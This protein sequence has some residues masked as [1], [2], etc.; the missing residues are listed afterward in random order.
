MALADSHDEV[1]ASATARSYHRRQFLAT[2]A[3]LVAVGTGCSAPSRQRPAGGV[4]KPKVVRRPLPTVESGTFYSKARHRTVGWTISYPPNLRSHVG[5]PLIFALHPYTGNHSFPMGG[6]PPA[7]LLT[8]RPGRAVIP[9]VAVAA[10]D[11]GNGYWHRHPGDDPMMMLVKEFLPM[12]RR[13]GLGHGQRI[14]VIG[15][16]MGGYGALLL[17]E[18]HVTLVAAVGVVS[19]AIWLSYQ[20]SQ[21]AN[22]T[23]FTSAADFDSRD[24]VRLAAPLSRTPVW[25]AS[26]VED[27]FHSGVEAL[28]SALPPAHVTYPRGGHNDAFFEA[29][30]ARA[31]QF[32]AAHLVRAR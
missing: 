31:L 24:V 6:I 21:L 12:C 16:S 15:T 13:R 20:D 8:M 3:A 2:L 29:H 22:P 9:P 17:A 32:T 28:A 27:P 4:T 7:R 5:L 23:A 25:V 11:G 18:T 14:G 10:V 30:A 19:P 26:G 1:H